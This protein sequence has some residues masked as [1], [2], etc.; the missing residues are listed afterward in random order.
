MDGVQNSVRI[1]GEL[2]SSFESRRGLRQGDGLSCLLFN[3]ALEGVMRRAGLNSRGTIFTKS[4]QFVL[5][6]FGADL[7]AAAASVEQMCSATTSNASES[8]LGWTDEATHRRAVSAYRGYPV[9]TSLN[10]STFVSDE[11]FTASHQ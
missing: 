3:I 9:K 8:S 7:A 4:S 1:S 2:S 10:G 6:T 5:C 11:N